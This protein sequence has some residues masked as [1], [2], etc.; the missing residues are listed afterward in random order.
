MDSGRELE[1]E[2]KNDLIEAYNWSEFKILNTVV[3]VNKKQG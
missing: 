2:E 1:R 3:C